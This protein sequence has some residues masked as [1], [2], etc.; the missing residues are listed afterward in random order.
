MNITIAAVGRLKSGAA[1]TLFD[2]YLK[3]LRWSVK[4]REVS[5]GRG[6]S[7]TERLRN[8]AQALGKALPK[9][10]TVVALE[11]TGNQ[12]SSRKFAAQLEAWRDGG[13]QEL[14]FLIGGTDGLAAEITAKASGSLAL[15]P[16]TWPHF[17]VRAMLAEQLYRAYTISTGHP[18]HRE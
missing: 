13:V 1:K 14:A 2:D 17:L 8:E 5:N 10:A 15:G 12:F 16:Q 9:A 6:S 11:E 18:Y 3:R 7:A 4:L